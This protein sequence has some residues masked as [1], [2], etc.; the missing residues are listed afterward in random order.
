M[1]HVSFD[2]MYQIFPDVMRGVDRS[3]L[4][5]DACEY[6]KHTRTSYVSKGI[7]SISP[8]VLVHSDVWTCPVVSISGAKYFVTF[9]DCYSRM[10][11]IYLM[12]HKDEVFPCFKKFYALVQNQFNVQI[13]AI[14]TDNGTEYVNKIF[15]AFMSEQGIL[16]QTSCPD[17]PQ[18]NGVAERKNHHI[19]EVARALM[20]TMN[21]PKF[22]WSE[23]VL[24]ATYL[25]NR[26]PLRV[27]GMKSPC[28]LILKDNTFVVP[29]KLFG[30]TCFVR[31]HRSS[32]SKLDPRALKCIFLGYSSG[33]RGYKCW[34]PSER[35]TFVSMDVTFRESEPFY[36]EKT[37]LSILFEDLDHFPAH[38]TGQEGESELMQGETISEPQ[39]QPI[40]GLIPGRQDGDGEGQNLP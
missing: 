9:I 29:P 10:T 31:D 36:G 23:A 30:C 20:F 8:F 25:I 39:P 13:Q 22:L 38:G 2:K 19:L 18:Q 1:G 26:T 34:S 4:K 28:E 35:R 24:T 7:R 3:K 6:A 27:T 21:V 17:T 12:R 40:V 32:V 5:C 14:R 16:H 11:W 33:Q 15:G 37:D